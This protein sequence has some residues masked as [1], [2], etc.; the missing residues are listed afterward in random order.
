[1]P[2]FVLPT[3][4]AP[5]AL[6]V[7]KVLY[8]P[9]LSPDGASLLASSLHTNNPRLSPDGWSVAFVHSDALDDDAPNH[10]CVATMRTGH[11]R[12][13]AGELQGREGIDQVSVFGV[14]LHVS[15]KDGA[16]LEQAT[17]PYRARPGFAWVKSSP[18]LEDVFIHLMAPFRARLTG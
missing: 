9:R 11:V 15:G 8:N 1:M 13:L 18:S 14:T 17:A 3:L 6:S 2:A 10:L 16:K 4:S 7:P 5:N 12:T